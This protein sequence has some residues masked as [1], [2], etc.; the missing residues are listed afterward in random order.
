M[1]LTAVAFLAALLLAGCGRYEGIQPERGWPLQPRETNPPGWTRED[2]N[3]AYERFIEDPPKTWSMR[4]VL[5]DV[6]PVDG[7]DEHCGSLQPGP[8]KFQDA[9]ILL[10]GYTKDGREIFSN[11]YPA[12]QVA[13]W[14]SGVCE[15]PPVV[16]SVPAADHYRVGVGH[17]GMGLFDPTRPIEPGTFVGWDKVTVLVYD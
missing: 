7:Y 16:V 14:A 17:E 2:V 9:W 8:K 13:K 5:R 3:E 1:R 11:E 4:L 10:S 15:A 6:A 12:P